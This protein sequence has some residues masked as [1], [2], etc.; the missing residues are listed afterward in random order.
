MRTNIQ[1]TVSLGDVIV[2][3]YDQAALF[4]DDP[5]EISRLAAR[6]IQIMLQSTKRSAP[7]NVSRSKT[8]RIQ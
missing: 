3:A 8:M 2:A 4:S 1:K 7:G 6:V 5:L